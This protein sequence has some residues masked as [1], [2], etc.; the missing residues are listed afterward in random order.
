MSLSFLSLL[1]QSAQLPG[2]QGCRAGVQGRRGAEE[3]HQKSL[4]FS[5]LPSLCFP[6][7][8]LP[9]RLP[10]LSSTSFFSRLSRSL[11]YFFFFFSPSATPPP[12]PQDFLNEPYCWEPALILVPVI[13]SVGWL[14]LQIPDPL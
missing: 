4:N 14:L 13:R 12:P 3:Q 2:P 11:I 6:R 9:W 7:L 10:E 5:F 1:L 8:Q